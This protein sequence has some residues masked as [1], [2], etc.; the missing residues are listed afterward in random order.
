MWWDGVRPVYWIFLGSV[1]AFTGPSVT[2]GWLANVVIGTAAAVLMFEIV[3]R[4]GDWTLGAVAG[5][6]LALDFENARFAL[7]LASEP[8][9]NFLALLAMYFLVVGTTA[10]MRRSESPASQHNRS[11]SAAFFAGG[12]ALALSNLARPLNLAAAATLPFAVALVLRRR[13]IRVGF[14]RIAGLTLLFLGGLAVVI[15]PWMARQY[16]KYGVLTISV[17]S[18]EMTYAAVTRKYGVWTPAVGTLGDRFASI[19]DRVDFYNRETIRNLAADPGFFVTRTGRDL[20]RVVR[21]TSPERWP[22]QLTCAVWLAVALARGR[23]SPL[24]PFVAAAAMAGCIWLSPGAV[25]ASLWVAA[26]LLA[27]LTRDPMAVPGALIATTVLTMAMISVPYDARIYLQCQ[28][29]AVILSVWLCWRVL[30]AADR[31]FAGAVA[32]PPASREGPRGWGRAGKVVSIAAAAAV[33]VLLA[34]TAK[35]LIARADPT[36][37]PQVLVS[38]DDAAP[39]IRAT[40]GG[41]PEYAPVEPRLQVRRARLRPPYSISFAAGER[42]DHWNPLFNTA[43]PYAFTVFETRPC[44]FGS[45]QRITDTAPALPKI[46]A[47]YPGG[48][49]GLAGEDLVFVGVPVL[50]DMEGSS[51]EVVAIGREAAGPDPS[52]LVIAPP[53]VRAQHARVLATPPP[54]RLP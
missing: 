4:L 10:A 1:F 45:E 19:K 21:G 17:N 2:A 52:R 27:C 50:R 28:A 53:A 30:G 38:P 11:V 51:F 8:L 32:S 20:I 42:L 34:G 47:V 25:V 41:A 44:I 9:G 12:A 15:A 36:P 39:W 54:R 31:L 33:V 16:L 49:A 26:T 14:R 6:A 24:V 7:S 37:S 13:D 43:R 5:I 3:R 22:L 40:I 23:R 18:A 46:Y 35:A 48:L 29:F